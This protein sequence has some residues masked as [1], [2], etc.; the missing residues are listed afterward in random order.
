MKRALWRLLSKETVGERVRRRASPS[1]LINL[2]WDSARQ[3]RSTALRL[4]Q[5]R[6]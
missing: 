1:T 3:A 4:H 2:Q 6:S 5:N